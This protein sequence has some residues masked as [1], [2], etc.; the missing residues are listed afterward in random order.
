MGAY[1]RELEVALAAVLRAARVCQAVAAKLRAD[2]TVTKGDQSPVTVADYAAQVVIAQALAAAFP[3]DLLVGEESTAELDKAGA[4]LAQ[5]V[6]ARAEVGSAEE[7]RSWIARAE[8]Q[9]GQR[10]WTVDPVDGTKGFVRQQ[11]YAVA[12]ALVVDGRPVVGA[13]ACPNLG[14]TREGVG[15][16]R[17]SI[18]PGEPGT[19]FGAQRG[20]GVWSG[21]LGK[22]VAKLARPLAPRRRLAESAVAE[23]ANRE[24]QEAVDRA[25][26]MTEPPV[27]IDS[28][29]KYALV[30]RGDAS[31]Y[32]RFP[33]GEAHREK[34]WDHAAG[35]LLVEESG[36]AVTDAH[37]RPLDFGHGR[38]LAANWGV[39]ATAG[40]DHQAVLAALHQLQA[41]RARQPRD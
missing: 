4:Q 28:Q 22:T 8:A 11:Q 6:A 30:A 14:P 12:L 9:P 20:G 21:E 19:L 25:L 23:H 39:I 17:P 16:A 10:F 31:V 2:W 32:L 3:T 29:A 27:R 18:A 15:E 41:E 33:R 35:A 7:V 24:L 37:G 1:D 36:G 26:G 34:I 40:M 5:E 38:T 13:L